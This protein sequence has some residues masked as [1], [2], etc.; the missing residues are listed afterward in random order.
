MVSGGILLLFL[1]ARTVPW[2]LFNR[3]SL[4]RRCVLEKSRAEERKSDSRKEGRKEGRNGERMLT[5]SS[6][7]YLQPE[8]IQPLPSTLDVNNSPLALLAQTC[9]SI[10]KDPGP[11]SKSTSGSAS[12]KKSSHAS[13]SGGGA[14]E[15]SSSRAKS[16]SPSGKNSS[17]S[18]ERSKSRPSGGGDKKDS[19]AGQ[20]SSGS[21]GTPPKTGFRVPPAP[22]KE[23][24]SGN[25]DRSNSDSASGS[26]S[27][28][29]GHNSRDGQSTTLQS[30]TGRT[31]GGSSSGGG[32][33]PPGSGNTCSNMLLELNQEA[34]NKSSLHGSIHPLYSS[35]KDS[36]QALHGSLGPSLGGCTLPFLGYPL[37]LDPLAAYSASLAAHCNSLAGISSSQKSPAAPCVNTT[38]CS[39][40]ASLSPY[41]S[42]ARV[43]TASG[44]TTLVQVCK[45]PYCTNCQVALHGAQL[46]AQ[47]PC[48]GPGCSQCAQHDKTSPTSL[49]SPVPTGI[50]F[51]PGVP[52]VAGGGGGLPSLCSHA[53]FTSASAL[54]GSPH[55]GP[56]VTPYVC[57]W[58]Q[59]NEYCGKRFSSS[60][61][62]LQHLRSHTS[63]AEAAL[64]SPFNAAAA[65][66]IPLSALGFPLGG[67]FGCP[68]LS[69]GLLSPPSY[70][71]SLSP[72]TLLAAARY[73]PYKHPSLSILPGSS[74]PILSGA[75]PSLA[76]YYSPY[77]FYGQRLGAAAAAGP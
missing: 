75:F 20:R 28:E 44:G 15:S 65:A 10:G 11:S 59:G 33:P 49:A 62:L 57:N 19:S 66:G 47:T 67:L 23:G 17:N 34:L 73:H 71:R 25:S 35:L 48:T 12:D 4:L 55:G 72:N 29:I 42:Y 56:L 52:T 24:S 53:A 3:K 30:N 40:A 77:A 38:P 46:G 69:P 21:K 13:S 8:Y 7:Q 6:S 68:S 39:A 9:S 45:D 50:P 5:T 64:V 54:A 76:A 37:S 51:Y 61:E 2:I 41:V 26:S 43:K 63:T 27:S 22:P 18:E 31:M 32:K 58:V 1:F 74:T 70:P 36:L 60:E 16:E 14:K